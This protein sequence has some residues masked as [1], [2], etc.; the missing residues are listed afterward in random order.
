MIS[1][2]FI[3]PRGF[4]NPGPPPSPPPRTGTTGT[5]STVY[6]P[7]QR[8]RIERATKGGRWRRYGMLGSNVALWVLWL[9]AFLLTRKVFGPFKLLQT[10]CKD[11]DGTRLLNVAT[12]IFLA[13]GIFVFVVF[14]CNY[15]TQWLH[16]HLRRLF[17]YNRSGDRWTRLMLPAIVSGLLYATWMAFLWTAYELAAQPDSSLLSATEETATF[18]TVLSIALCMRPVADIAK[19]LMKIHKRKRREKKDAA[20]KLTAELEPE[21][22]LLVD[23]HPSATHLPEPSPEI[24]IVPA[25]DDRRP[26]ASSSSSRRTGEGGERRRHPNE[27]DGDEINELADSLP[28]SEQSSIISESNTDDDDERARRKL[29]RPSW[30]S[31]HSRSRSRTGGSSEGDRE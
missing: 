19:A 25:L 16:R 10:N 6:T 22:P 5:G 9:F 18:P 13:V 15:Y 29:K 4:V 1:S 28:S 12:I 30:V 17:D 3:R 14:V 20:R 2:S 23:A 24:R 8:H 26:L 27:V 31:R 11:P 7:E 21:E